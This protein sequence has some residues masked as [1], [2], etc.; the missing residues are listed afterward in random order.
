MTLP[1]LE[2]LG[3]TQN[4]IVVYELLISRGKLTGTEII[5]ATGIKRATVYKSLYS[6]SDKGLVKQEDIKKKLHFSPLHPEKLLELSEEQL[7]KQKRTRQDIQSILPDLSS[8]YVLNIEKPVVRFYEGTEGIKKANLEIL[9]EKKEILA[10]V[11]ADPAIDKSL[12]EFWKQYYKIRMRDNIRVRAISPDNKA[13]VEYKKRDEKELRTT[14]LVP[15]KSFPIHIEKNIVGNKVAF[16]S[17]ENGKLIATVIE[18][19]L[20][21]DTERA[22]FELS[23][24]EAGRYQT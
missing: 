8:D 11:Y 10:Y 17:R 23:W 24:K 13:S 3:L 2:T 12:D 1:F 15:E 18:N 16:F 21:A 20:I 9:A 14:Y 5:K 7:E 6:L 4:E 19:K 22:I